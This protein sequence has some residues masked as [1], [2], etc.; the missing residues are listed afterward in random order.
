MEMYSEVSN[1]LKGR[2][3]S[4][5]DYDSSK[6]IIGISTSNVSL[7]AQG[8]I[9]LAKQN[10]FKEEEK[11]NVDEGVNALESIDLTPNDTEVVDFSSMNSTIDTPTLKEPSAVSDIAMD[12][13][14]SVESPASLGKFVTDIP[15][16]T[17]QPQEL[18]QPGE[19]PVFDIQMPI[20]PDKIVATE[21]KEIDPSLFELPKEEHPNLEIPNDNEIVMPSVLTTEPASEIVA[22]NVEETHEEKLVP[23]ENPLPEA[24]TVINE[25]QVVET[26]EEVHEAS[27]GNVDEILNNLK[28]EIMDI[29]SKKIDEAIN[30]I[31]MMEDN[32]SKTTSEVNLENPLMSDA[33][34]QI[35]NMVIPTG[36]VE[37][38]PRL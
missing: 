1:I 11:T 12:A 10:A 5:I 16:E 35:N 13:P 9:P 36:S 28:S 14:V 19:T 20:M 26:K 2:V 8:V 27:S 18:E 30:K 17:Q 3:E 22:P 6:K 23:E 7:N 31:K 4:T 33:F 34:A 38:G 32:K 37:Q 29:V 24:S 25:P 15:E 21:P